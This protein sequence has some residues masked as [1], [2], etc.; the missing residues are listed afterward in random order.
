VSL[1]RFE[2]CPSRKLLLCQTSRQG[3]RGGGGTGAII[4]EGRN[5]GG[6]MKLTEKFEDRMDNKKRRSKGAN[7]KGMT[8]LFVD[9]IHLRGLRT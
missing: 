3:R 4:R 1:P 2:P 9:T 6:E 5:E 8:M 7:M